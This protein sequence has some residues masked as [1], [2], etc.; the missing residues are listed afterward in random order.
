MPQRF[1]EGFDPE[2]VK[3]MMVA[4]DQACD[5]LALKERMMR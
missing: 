5:R 3:A 2:T 1:A 4:F